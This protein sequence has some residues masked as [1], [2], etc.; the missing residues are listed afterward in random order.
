ML[1]RKTRHLS[2]DTEEIAYVPL[3]LAIHR[4]EQEVRRAAEV[5]YKEGVEAYSYT[6]CWTK[7]LG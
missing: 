3:E 6:E 5:E 2:G 1:E 4:E 7:R